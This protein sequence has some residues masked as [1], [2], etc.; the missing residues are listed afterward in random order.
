MSHLNTTRLF[1][2]SALAVVAGCSA[3]PDT[4]ADFGNSV[5]HMVSSQTVDPGPV[6][7]S[8]VE[9]GDGQRLDGVLE[10]YRSGAVSASDLDEP[11]VEFDS[12]GSQ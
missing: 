2:L 5:R 3:Y 7:A 9:T 11:S 12:S 1:A 4:K 10:D 6:D 8:P